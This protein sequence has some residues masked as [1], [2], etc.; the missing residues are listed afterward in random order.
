MKTQRSRN[1]FDANRRYSSV[2]QQQGRM[3]TDADWNELSDLVKERLNDVL[4][5]VTG[6][7]TPRRR[8]MVVE[9]TAADG[10]TTHELHWGYVYVDGIPAQSGPLPDAT[11]ADPDS[12]KFEYD[13]QAD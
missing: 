9:T 4:R 8:G 10:S 2:Y 11:L 3:L 6:G 5:D 12:R 13:H 1:T 7:G